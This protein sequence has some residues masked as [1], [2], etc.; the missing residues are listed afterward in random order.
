MHFTTAV[1]MSQQPP[2]KSSFVDLEYSIHYIFIYYTCLSRASPNFIEGC[3]APTEKYSRSFP[4]LKYFSSEVPVSS[5]AAPLMINKQSYIMLC[6][7]EDQ[8]HFSQPALTDKLCN[9]LM[10]LSMS[11]VIWNIVLTRC[12]VSCMGLNFNP[13]HVACVKNK[14]TLAAVAISLC[15]F[16]HF[17]PDCN[18]QTSMI[19]RAWGPWLSL[20]ATWRFTLLQNLTTMD[21]F[22]LIAMKFGT[23]A[24]WMK[25]ES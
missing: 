11:H 4:D 13:Q 9:S 20:S 18:A 16:H 5:P 8:S 10:S 7:E 2:L 14:T 1:C 12:Y 19:C 22:G 24:E 6:F 25:A 17:C 15:W 21:W 3:W 23:D